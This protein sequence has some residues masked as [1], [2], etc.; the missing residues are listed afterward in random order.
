MF[1][2]NCEVCKDELLRYD[3]KKQKKKKSHKPGH[4]ITASEEDTARSELYNPVKC[5]DCG[6]VIAVYDID[7]VFHFFNI[8]AS[9]A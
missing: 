6:T 5:A 8:L 4:L 2:M 1:V 9:Q 7:E 3:N